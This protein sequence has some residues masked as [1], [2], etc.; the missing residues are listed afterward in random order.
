MCQFNSGPS[1]L[2]NTDIHISTH[3]TLQVH[4]FAQSHHL[5]WEW[6]TEEKK[7]KTNTKKTLSSDGMRFERG[8]EPYNQ[9]N[10]NDKNERDTTKSKQNHSENGLKE[11]GQ[12]TPWIQDGCTSREYNIY[13]WFSYFEFVAVRTSSVPFVN[14]EL[15]SIGLAESEWL[16]ISNSVW[17]FIF[18]FNLIDRVKLRCFSFSVFNF[19]IF[20]HFI[21]TA[22]NNTE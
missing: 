11:D 1:I 8:C 14:T 7:R 18:S 5:L 19:H 12:K 6:S 13:K 3:K 15:V 21:I 9:T 16:V 4:S 22:N 20:C 2:E 10:K 17:F